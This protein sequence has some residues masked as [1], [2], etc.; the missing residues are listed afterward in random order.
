[1]IGQKLKLLRKNRH[2]TLDELAK[3]LN[4]K[5][6]DTFNFNKGRLSKWENNKDEPRLSSIVILA[7]FF[8]VSVDYF[9]DRQTEI[10]A[11]FDELNTNRQN[12]VLQ[13]AHSELEQQ[14]NEDDKVVPLFKVIGTTEAAAARGL[15]YGFD[16][17]DYDTYSVY[18][19]EEPPAYDVATR[20]SGNSM[21]P[22]YKDGDMLYLIDSGISKYSGQLCVV[23]YNDQTYFKKVY[24]EPD[25][26]RL[27]SLNSDYD[28]IFIDYPPESGTHLKIFSVV[29]SF[30]PIEN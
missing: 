20:V 17:D 18:T 13:F 28:D 23:S 2:L 16:F 9:T 15:G 26:L 11:V 14:N 30:T 10:Q 1:M 19:D 5:Y 25:G 24:T 4:E 3:Q 22:D 27:V 8:G 21:L 12:K 7:D 6:P 29:G